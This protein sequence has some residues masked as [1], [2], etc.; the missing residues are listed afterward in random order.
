MSDAYKTFFGFHKE[1]FT[2]ELA[3]KDILQTEDIKGVSERFNYAVRLGA[4]AVVTGEVG[5]GKS[6]AALGG[7]PAAPL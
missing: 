2:A 1:P 6:T 7:Q 4:M 5:S 3:L